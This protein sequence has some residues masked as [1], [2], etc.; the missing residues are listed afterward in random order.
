[1]RPARTWWSTRRRSIGSRPDSSQN[2]KADAGLDPGRTG[3]LRIPEPFGRRLSAG[4]PEGEAELADL[5]EV[6]L[7]AGAVQGLTVDELDDPPG[8]RVVP[9]GGRS[10][11]HEAVHTGR[12]ASGQRGRCD[13]RQ[14]HRTRDRLRGLGDHA[15]RIER[16]GAIAAVHVQRHGDRL[17]LR[18]AIPATIRISRGM[19]APTS[20]TSTPARTAPYSVDGVGIWIFSRKLMP[21]SPSWPSSRATP[22]RTRRSSTARGSCDAARP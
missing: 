6:H 8:R 11:D 3:V 14:E 16:E 13:D 12:L 7:V 17:V 22:P 9:A 20:T 18:E 19:P 2:A 5:L 10:L 21:T 15:S 4:E 1:M